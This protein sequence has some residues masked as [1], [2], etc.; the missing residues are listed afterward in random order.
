MELL[1][2]CGLKEMEKCQV[3]EEMDPVMAFNLFQTYGFP[4]EMINEELLKKLR[5]IFNYFCGI[6]TYNAVRCNVL[7]DM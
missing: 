1:R 5:S 4:L 2:E 6:S 7:N 3:S